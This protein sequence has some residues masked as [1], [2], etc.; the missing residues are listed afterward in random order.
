MFCID[1]QSN[2]LNE[3]NLSSLK[4]TPYIL[5]FRC[6]QNTLQSTKF[7]PLQC[8]FVKSCLSTLNSWTQSCQK[9][10]ILRLPK[11]SRLKHEFQ[12]RYVIIIMVI[13]VNYIPRINFVYKLQCF[14]EFLRRK[15]ST[16]F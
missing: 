12:A 5:E 15:K 14:Q 2:C 13:I 8:Q 11:V 3:Q 1:E 9:S 7:T 6:I 10:Q 4:L 16:K